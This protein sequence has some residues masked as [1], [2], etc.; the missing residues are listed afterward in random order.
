MY[1][2]KF[3]TY[4]KEV[5]TTEDFI[6]RAV[7]GDK[8][9]FVSLMQENEKYMYCIGKSILKNDY[10]VADAM[11]D[12]ILTA[13]TKISSLKNYCNFRTWLTKILLNKCYDIVR[14][15]KSCVNIDDITELSDDVDCFSSKNEL[16]FESL[17]EKSKVIMTLYY[18]Y[19]YQVKEIAQITGINENTVKTRLMRGRKE[20]ETI[21]K[22]E[23][24]A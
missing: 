4:K 24:L 3:L 19:G 9:A 5:K 18:K 21:I 14:K 1:V 16:D 8:K 20:Y 10:D 7:N 13:F 17:C 15:N 2:K 6:K 12:A 11:Q 22:K 23:G